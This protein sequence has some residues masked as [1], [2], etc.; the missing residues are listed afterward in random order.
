MNLS[1]KIRKDNKRLTPAQRKRVVAIL[2]S[3]AERVEGGADA[4]MVYFDEGSGIPIITH[5]KHY[6]IGSFSCC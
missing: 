6:Q 4:G 2:R 3:V 5:N 1:F